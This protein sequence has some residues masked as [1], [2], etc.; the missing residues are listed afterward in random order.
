MIMWTF[1]QIHLYHKWKQFSCERLQRN[2]ATSLILTRYTGCRSHVMYRYFL[3]Y[4][5]YPRGY[6]AGD[7]SPY[8]PR[9]RY[10]TSR[11][12]RFHAIFS[13]C[14]RVTQKIIHEFR[15]H[16][17]TGFLHSN[18]LTTLISCHPIS[19]LVN[20]TIIDFMLFYH[21]NKHYTSK[22]NQQPSNE[23]NRISNNTCLCWIVGVSGK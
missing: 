17:K 10:A 23:N 5:I 11:A 3:G 1:D 7:S 15:F 16:L 6:M 22:R 14:N 2:V 4:A 21:F 20:F 13:D 18:L 9:R 12:Q 8:N 19:R